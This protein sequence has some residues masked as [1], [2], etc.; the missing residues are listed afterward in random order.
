MKRFIHLF[1]LAS[2]L[3]IS[4]CASHQPQAQPSDRATAQVGIVNHTGNY[5]YSASVDGAGGGNMARW[6]QG[7]ANICCTS[8]P[9]VWY[10]GMKVLVRWN[11]PIGIQDVIKEKTVE[12]EKYD[13][14]GSIYMH[15][16][17]ND[18][19]R[20]VVSPVIPGSPEYPIRHLGNPDAPPAS[21]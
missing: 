19:V 16:F 3:A 9:R 11:M 12:V 5:I 6:G 14:P 1:A 21:N 18:E 10:P 7:F 15:F 8:I 13:K 2:A 4:G 20:V 17:P